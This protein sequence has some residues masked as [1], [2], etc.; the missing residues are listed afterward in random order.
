MLRYLFTYTI[1]TEQH[2][3][4]ST[5]SGRP[6]D[7]IRAPVDDKRRGISAS[8]VHWP[9]AKRSMIWGNWK[10]RKGDEM[11]LPDET[12]EESRKSAQLE[13][14]SFSD[15]LLYPWYNMVCF[16]IFLFVRFLHFIHHEQARISCIGQFIDRPQLA[17]SG[18]TSL[19]TLQSLAFICKQGILVHCSLLKLT[20]VQIICCFETWH[21][22]SRLIISWMHEFFL[23]NSKEADV[24]SGRGTFSSRSDH[25]TP[26][27]FIR[28]SQPSAS[29][30][31]VRA[32]SLDP[33]NAGR[34]EGSMESFSWCNETVWSLERWS[35]PV[36]RF[37]LF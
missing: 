24:F 28:A 13:V 30:S 8:T 17:K 2:S 19:T 33:T 20:D 31:L 32:S 21:M 26:T 1:P 7:R 14:T 27:R 11:K 10:K 25:H 36:A 4:E 15:H 3:I 6:R 35:E 22:K 12:L 29:R 23:A 37:Q 9:W 5:S 18:S 34:N 16:F